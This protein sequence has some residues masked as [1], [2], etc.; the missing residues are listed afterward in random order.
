MLGVILAAGRGKRLG[1]LTTRRSKA[2]LPV[3][4]K[5]LVA[6]VLDSLIAAGID[7]V[8]IVVAAED[9][10]LRNYF[11]TDDYADVRIRLTTQ[12]QPRGMADALRCASSLITGDFVLSAC[13]SLV[14][15]NDVARLVAYWQAHL[16]AHG[17]LALL[18]VLPSQLGQ[19]G[20]VA[21]DGE[22]VRRI[23]EKPR[24]EEAPSDIISL[25]LYVFGPRLLGYLSTVQPSP[26]GE[27]E[28]QDA[29][30]QLIDAGGAIYGMTVSGR[31]TVTTPADL[32]AV[33]IAFLQRPG[34]SAPQPTQLPAHDI[35]IIEPV[36]IDQD[37]ALGSRCVI[38]PN[39]YLERGCVIGADV[40]LRDAL[41]LR[42]AIVPSGAI[43]ADQVV[44]EP[45]PD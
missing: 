3:V 44:A 14:S 17:L 29:V 2:M 37:V 40:H 25:P 22:R 12:V 21:L 20:V 30:Q 42:G 26:R 18:R 15:G 33:N 28:L 24:A 11:A 32:L 6:R 1:Q 39:V 7:D 10:E 43:I 16:H 35:Q 27:Y 5:P 31:L 34:T 8:I 19:S 45:I 13:D 41:V 23:V 38:G 4:G 36:A 9:E